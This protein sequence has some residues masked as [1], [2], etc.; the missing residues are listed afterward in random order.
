MNYRKDCYVN[1]NLVGIEPI[2]VR[3]EELH[4]WGTQEKEDTEKQEEV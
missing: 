2:L 3:K 4:D 1:E